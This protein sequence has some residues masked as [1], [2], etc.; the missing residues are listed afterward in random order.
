M[1]TNFRGA[2]GL[3]TGYTSDAGPCFVGVA[4]RAGRTLGVVLLNAPL[5]HRHA[6]VL[7]ERGFRAG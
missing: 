4:R 6:R 1:R 3:K 7:L 2:I 5:V